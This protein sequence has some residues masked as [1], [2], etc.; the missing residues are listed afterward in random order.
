MTVGA[1]A[2]TARPRSSGG[3]GGGV[4]TRPL[5]PDLGRRPRRRRRRP[6][7]SSSSS[8]LGPLVVLEDRPPAGRRVRLRQDQ[9]QVPLVQAGR[10]RPDLVSA[11]RQSHLVLHRRL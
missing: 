11:G 9:S 10:R 1:A 3:L 8:V 7:D 4:G 6:T 2:T 5:C